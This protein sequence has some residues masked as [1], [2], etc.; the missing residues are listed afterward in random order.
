[1]FAHVIFAPS[2]YI[3]CTRHLPTLCP[4]TLGPPAPTSTV[5]PLT[6]I[7]KTKSRAQ[8]GL[9]GSCGLRGVAVDRVGSVRTRVRNAICERTLQ[10][11]GFTRER[12]RPDFDIA[13][14]LTW[15]AYGIPG[16]AEVKAKMERARTSAGYI[17]EEPTDGI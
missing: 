17:T 9:R 1:M 4:S 15:T 8:A 2:I 6:C 5:T 11:V 3:S 14:A 10:T 7:R 13:R 12:E 16:V